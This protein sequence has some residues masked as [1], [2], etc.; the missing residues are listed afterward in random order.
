MKAVILAAG[1][2][3]R[4]RPLTDDL[5]KPLMPVLGRPLLWHI[6][7]SLQRCKVDGIGINVHHMA[8]QVEAYCRAAQ[9][10]VD[11]RLSHEEQIRGVAGG[12]GG[13]RDFLAGEDFFLVHNGDV[14]TDIDLAKVVAAYRAEP[15]LCS[16]VLHDDPRF[17]NVSVD[18]GGRIV[19]L[20][21]TLRPAGAWRRLAYT[22]IA[23]MSGD[24]LGCIPEGF[25]E[26]VPLV[27]DI[28]SRSPERVR[29]IIVSG[30]RWQDLGTIPSYFA[31][32]RE[33]L[34]GRAPLVDKALVPAGA[35]WF[36]RG[37]CRGERAE[38][39]GFISAGDNCRIGSGCRLENCIL[40]D[41]AAIADGA[42]VS[43]AI[44]GKSW[45]V[46]VQ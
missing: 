32:H 33:I 36:G 42:R 38:L 45:V 11:V 7:T 24:F 8:G 14:L 41:G 25:A 17:N 13:L 20:R 12:I 19:D 31:A 21:D 34:I 23:V 15:A 26:L 4:L 9:F 39:H 29:G 6:I 22:G 40:W 27:L 46:H 5:P 35:F 43:N 28:I 44:L 3:T 2:G 18:A 16:L 37:C 30:C 10:G 1:Y